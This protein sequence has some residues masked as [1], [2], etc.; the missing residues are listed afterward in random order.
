MNNVPAG[1]FSWRAKYG[2]DYWEGRSFSEWKY[3]IK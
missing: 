2:K 3:F 1:L